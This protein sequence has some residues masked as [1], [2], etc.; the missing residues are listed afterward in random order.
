MNFSPR[1]RAVLQALL[2]TFLWS[3]SW[4]LIKLYIDD[5]PPLLFAGLRYFI[6]FLLLLPGLWKFKAEVRRLSSKQ[7]GQLIALGLVFYTLTQGG[8]FITLKYLKA[9]T[10]NILLNF[11]ALLVAVLGIIFLKEKLTG[12]QW[13]GMFIFIFGIITYFSLPVLSGGNLIGYTMAGITVIAN[14]VASILG[15]SVN[16][17]RQISPMVVTVTSMGVGAVVLLGGGLIFQRLPPLS[18]TI[19]GAI[20]WLAVVNTAFAFYLWNKTLQTLTALESSIINSTMLIQI[21]VLAWI[22]LGE[23]ITPRG[24]IG[25]AAAAVGVFLVNWRKPDR[26]V[27]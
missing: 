22:F 20:L 14:G 13:L 1:L 5:I 10:F 16:R 2:V 18:I 3:T 7:W 12:S 23:R 17:D 15:R 26:R 6:A 21:A 9:M 4:V 8:Q 11:S 24:I 25:L 19:W 27:N